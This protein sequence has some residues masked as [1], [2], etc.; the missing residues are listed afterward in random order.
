MAGTLIRIDLWLVRIDAESGLAW[1][2]S[3]ANTITL[4]RDAT[5][6]WWNFMIVQIWQVRN[7]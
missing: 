4:Y 3:S 1:M 2:D 6:I 7:P 5:D